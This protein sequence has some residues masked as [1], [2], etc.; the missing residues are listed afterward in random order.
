M[1]CTVEEIMVIL[2]HERLKLPENRKERR[3][4]ILAVVRHRFDFEE[5]ARRTLAKEWRRRNEQEKKYFIHVFSQLL[6]NTYIN[7]IEAYSN[8]EVVFS[9]ESI[10]KNKAA[11]DTSIRHNDLEIPIQY[12]LII[13]GDE[14]R[15]YDVVIEGVSLVR[16]YRSQF[17]SI[18]K[19][20]KYAGLVKRL[21]E[22]IQI[23]EKEES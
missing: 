18:L 12:K 19:K 10:V 13:S 5:M 15:V 16:N 3:M 20:E 11:V 2:N 23:I 6:E 7:K 14:W 8:E 1:R 9:N 4:L 22:K 21:D 17:R